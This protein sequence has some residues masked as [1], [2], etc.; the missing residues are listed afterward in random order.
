MSHNG[1]LEVNNMIEWSSK[2][3]VSMFVGSCH[4]QFGMDHFV[5]PQKRAQISDNP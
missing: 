5:M 2:A 4:D 1:R 3:E